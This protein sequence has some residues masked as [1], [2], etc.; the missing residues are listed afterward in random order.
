MGAWI[1]S[2]LRSL[3]KNKPLPHTLDDIRVKG[4]T[5]GIDLSIYLHKALSTS[6]GSRQAT[7]VPSI[8]VLAIESELSKLIKI[9]GVHDMNA[10]WVLD[11]LRNPAK[12]NEDEKRAKEAA[13]VREKLAGLY[14]ANNEADFNEAT[15]LRKEL[16]QVT[17]DMLFVAVAYLQKHKQEIF[18]APF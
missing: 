11:G 1:P 16:S 8:P 2:W 17:E 4:K 10:V 6:E 12:S 13:A 3:K 5:V 14:A 18:V 15:K 7:S 9:L